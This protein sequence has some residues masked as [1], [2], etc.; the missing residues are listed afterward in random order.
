MSF[1]SN[2]MDFN[3]GEKR[4]KKSVQTYIYISLDIISL[5]LLQIQELAGVPLLIK[6]HLKVSFRFFFFFTFNI[7]NFCCGLYL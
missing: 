6:F 4:L 5:I 2:A 7:F 1:L 3:K